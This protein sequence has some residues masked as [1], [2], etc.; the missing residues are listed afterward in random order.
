M[1]GVQLREIEWAPAK[2]APPVFVAAENPPEEYGPWQWAAAFGRATGRFGADTFVLQENGTLRCPAGASLHFGE[3]RQENAFT[4]A[5][6][7]CRLPDRLSALS[8]A[9]AV[10]GTRS[11]RQS[12]EPS[13]VLSAVCY[14]LLRLLSERPSFSDRCGGWMWQADPFVAPG[15]RDFRRQYVEI[16]PL[17]QT[18]QEVLPP[19]RPPRAIRSHDRWSWHDRLARNA[20]WG[21][22]Q[23]RVSVAGVPA[24]LASS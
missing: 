24:F 20:W 11:Q 21:P 15:W 19:P 12:C 23:L 4:R 5:G 13:S 3:V 7:L 2:E 9:R 18:Q 22:P 10:S 6:C 8:S 14:P 16:L 17:V 1:Q